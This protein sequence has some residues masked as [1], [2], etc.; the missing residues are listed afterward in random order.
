MAASGSAAYFAGANTTAVFQFESRGMRDLLK[1]ARPDL[2]QEECKR[3]LRETARPIRTPAAHD[4]AGAGIIDAF[5]A[6]RSL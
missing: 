5:R 3:L 1:Q 4:G 6:F 2:T